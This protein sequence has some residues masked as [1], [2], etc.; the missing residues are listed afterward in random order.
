MSTS[1]CEAVVAQKSAKTA[2]END[3]KKDMNEVNIFRIKRDTVQ[4]LEGWKN[5]ERPEMI[6]H[7]NQRRC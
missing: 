2:T 1:G 7:Q 6:R 4:N 3:G 5:R